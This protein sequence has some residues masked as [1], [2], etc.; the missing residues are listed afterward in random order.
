MEF[1]PLSLSDKEAVQRITMGGPYRNCDINFMNLMS[2]RSLFGTELAASPGRLVF[3]FMLRDRLAYQV[4]VADGSWCETLEQVAADAHRK[5]Y[6]LLLMGVCR[7]AMIEIEHAFPGRFRFLLSRDF[8]D[9]VY[10]R[11]ALAMLAGKKLQAKRNHANKFS[12]L[13]PDYEFAPLR[14]KDLDD[15]RELAARWAAGRPAADGFIDYGSEQRSIHFVLDHWEALG[16]LGGVV[17]VD[18]RLVAFTYG[19]PVNNDTFDVCVE[20]ADTDY[21]GAYAVINR[22]FVHSLPGRYVYVN[23]EEDIGAAGLRKAKLSY[24]PVVLLEKF[25][26]TE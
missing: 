23:R 18:G 14:R 25:A 16:G 6:P 7:H 19:A 2:W 11:D 13:Y 3:R 4:V 20:K 10:R 15:C 24:H 5:G 26:V 22:D 1:R 21:E 9:Y 8:C 12:R 17:R